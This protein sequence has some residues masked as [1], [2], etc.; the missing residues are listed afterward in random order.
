MPV[1][2][3][4]ATSIWIVALSTL[5]FMIWGMARLESELRAIRKILE[6]KDSSE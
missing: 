4:D 3:N 2:H 5:V 1:T 6:R